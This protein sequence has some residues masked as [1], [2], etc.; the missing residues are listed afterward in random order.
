MN[1]LKNRSALVI[2]AIVVVMLVVVFVAVRASKPEEPQ[3]KAS[4]AP[5]ASAS[6]GAEAADEHE[7]LPKHVKLT[8][9]AVKD[10][11]IRTEPT[12]KGA[13]AVT[14]SL[15]GEIAADPDRSARIAS[16]AEGK[17]EEVRFK[18]GA[19]IKKG[20]TLAVVRVPE[21]GKV[22]GAQASTLAKAKAA[23]ANAN[24]LKALLEQ[25]LTS[26]QAVV[27]ADAEARALSVEAQALGEQLSALGAN[28][29]SGAPFLL[30]LR[31]PIDGTAI[32]RDAVIGQPVAADHTLG[33]IADLREVWFLARVFEKDLGRLKIGVSADVQ[34]NAYPK[35]RFQGKVD[36]I[37][38]TIDPVARTVT[39]RISLSNRNDLLRIGLF[40]MAH[41]A[42]GDSET[43]EPR[44][45]VPRSAVTEI[46]DKPVVFV[47]Q[48]DTEFELH[49]VVLGDGALG[50][51]EVIS[52]LRE[53]E[54]VVVEGVF[55]LKSV[56][57]KGTLEED[58]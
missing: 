14:I 30:A 13:L 15:P 9:D 11:S 12:R 38:Q 1:A 10:A 18:E 52:G 34:L 8:P 55:T 7:E 33:S 23:R 39:A 42:T 28:A 35:E 57:L 25:R 24:R 41:V 31:S 46:G 40:G 48:S 44:L 27:D 54:E 47:K 37:G 20:D 58:E 56:V 21:L 16:P 19:M 45:L 6:S 2:A 4:P 50:I 17:V 43:H 49:E 53:G 29:Q 3:V 36:Y 22:R 32:T 26:E 5:S 51:V